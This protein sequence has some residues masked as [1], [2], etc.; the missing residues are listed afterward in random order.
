MQLLIENRQK[1]VKVDRRR[2][3]QTANK[4][5]RELGCRDKEIS[6]ALVDNDQIR[7]INRQYLNRDYPT[8]VI[9]FSQLEGDFGDLNPT[10]LGDVVI[11]VE[12]A[13]GD[14]PAGGLTLDDELDFL[15]IHGLL[16]LLGYEHEN[17]TEA[18]AQRMKDKAE[19]LFYNLKGFK[20]YS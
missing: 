5:I 17:T 8:N 2:L 12:R 14:G 11:S 16:H 1:K 18:E 7:E 3:R 20:I 9:A 13:A 10:L 6:L 4:I 15:F 19:L